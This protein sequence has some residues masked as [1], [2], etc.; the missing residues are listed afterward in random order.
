MRVLTVNA[1]ILSTYVQQRL[2]NTVYVALVHSMKCDF[3]IL[4]AGHKRMFKFTCARDNHDPLGFSD[5]LNPI[6]R[7]NYTSHFIAD[8]YLNILHIPQTTNPCQ[9]H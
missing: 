5:A 3:F 7:R 8:K 1:K 9:T 6:Q 4:D 2:S